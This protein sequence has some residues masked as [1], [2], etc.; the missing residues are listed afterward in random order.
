MSAIIA[1]PMPDAM[2]IGFFDD[3]IKEI[4]EAINM[5]EDKNKGRR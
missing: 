3:N 5:I 4:K 1:Y 2:I